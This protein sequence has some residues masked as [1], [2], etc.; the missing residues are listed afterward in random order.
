[1]NSGNERPLPDDPVARRARGLFD[2]SV[3]ALDAA[4]LSRLN[5][6]RHRALEEARGARPGLRWSPWLPAGG[7][8]VAAAVAVLMVG[9]GDPAPVPMDADRAAD[10][11]II[12]EGD[13]FEMLEDLEFYSWMELERDDASHVG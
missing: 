5:R 3:E 2:E 10:L 8:A 9:G 1:M 12:L 4:T 6:G 7:V 11:E 13:D